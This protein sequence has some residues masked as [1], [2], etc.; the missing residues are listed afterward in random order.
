MQGLDASGLGATVRRVKA[1][2]PVWVGAG[3]DVV[4]DRGG[5]EILEFGGGFEVEGGGRVLA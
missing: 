4:V 1:L 2:H 5:E 3:G